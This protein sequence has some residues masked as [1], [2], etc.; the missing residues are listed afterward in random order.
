L[1]L[2]R[3]QGERLRYSNA[4]WIA[5]A[6]A[7]SDRLPELLSLI[8]E[9]PLS[10][11]YRGQ[12]ILDELMRLGETRRAASKAKPLIL[13]DRT[14]SKDRGS[15]TVKV[16]VATS[17]PETLAEE[18]ARLAAGSKHTN[19]KVPLIETLMQLGDTRRAAEMAHGVIAG[20]AVFGN[21]LVRMTRV[22]IL[23]DGLHAADG[24]IALL[25]ARESG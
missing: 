1:G 22:L 2:L 16:L 9:I 15:A 8:D 3:S 25:R 12:R 23:S 13:A 14:L 6:A 19:R 11:D 5:L 10:D 24:I 18:V 7:P 17:A 21:Q 20:Q 4:P